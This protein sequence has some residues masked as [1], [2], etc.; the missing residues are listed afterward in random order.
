MEPYTD[1]TYNPYS[2]TGPEEPGYWI[3]GA[4]GLER[5]RLERAGGLATLVRAA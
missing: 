4:K 1:P 2:T 3:L 5:V